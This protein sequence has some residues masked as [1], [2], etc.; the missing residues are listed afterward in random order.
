[1]NRLILPE[2]VFG[3]VATKTTSFGT[4]YAARRS[5]QW[6]C[7]VRGSMA[8]PTIADLDGDGALEILVSL[9]DTDGK[10]AVLVF[11]VQGSQ[12]N[13]VLWPTGRGNLLRNGWAR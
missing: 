10:A 7:T 12:T 9:K 11:A 1:M 5:R 13:C 8:V 4:L 3:K 2:A 6:A